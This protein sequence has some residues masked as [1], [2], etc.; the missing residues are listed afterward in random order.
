MPALDAFLDSEAE[1]VEQLLDNAEANYEKADAKARAGEPQ[2]A[3]PQA[4]APA[5]PVESTPREDEERTVPE[6]VAGLRQAIQAERAKRNDYKGERDRLA[7]EMAALKAELEAARK[8]AATPPAP[9]PQQAVERV[10]PRPIPNMIEDPAGY[11]DYME[12]KLFNQALNFSELM[13]RQKV[14]DDAAVDAA[15]AKFKELAKDNKPLQQELRDHQDPYKFAYDYVK[16]TQAMAEIGDPAAYRAKL[17]ADI[18]AKIEAEYAGTVSQ[19]PAAP[20][21]TLPQSL[22]T[23][24]SAAPR[25]AQVLNIPE[26][27]SDILRRR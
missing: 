6:D 4:E 21:V 27:F 25:S 16:K 19:Q 22:G 20:R 9:A 23:A 26:D 15:V 8:A 14:G 13:L 18:R 7:G 2:D 24:R 3:E 17:E 12:Q 1:A 11:H 5:A 10:Q